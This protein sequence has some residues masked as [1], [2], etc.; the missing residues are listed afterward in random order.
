MDYET[1]QIIYY[2]LHAAGALGA[3]M[4]FIF[5]LKRKGAG[6]KQIIIST[7][8]AFAGLIA[9]CFTVFSLKELLY[10]N[11]PQTGL[12][13]VVIPE[14]YMTAVFFSAYYI[15][16]S[17]IFNVYALTKAAFAESLM[18]FSFISRIGCCITGCCG[19]IELSGIT[20]PIQY[21]EL[22]F[23]LTVFILI[24]VFKSKNPLTAYL[25]L[26]SIFRFFTEF[27]RENHY[28]RIYF[29]LNVRQYTAIAVIIVSATMLI[30]IFIKGISRKT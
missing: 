24:K 17:Y 7:A 18:I 16:G 5:C 19:G 8:I 28:V 29:G 20:I 6:A 22:V 30:C 11:P 14:Y 9:A 26:Y 10:E 21:I 4:Y 3:S 27:M 15:C 13:S 23:A 1:E 12:S 25:L 2:A